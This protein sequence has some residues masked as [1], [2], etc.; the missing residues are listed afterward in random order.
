MER[1]N[2]K[3]ALSTKKS[4]EFLNKVYSKEVKFGWTI[5]LQINLIPKLKNPCVIPVGVVSQ[6]TIDEMGNAKEEMHHT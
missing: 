5:P 6:T 2:H 4:A 3:S 1:G